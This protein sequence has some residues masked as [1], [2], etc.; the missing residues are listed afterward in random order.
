MNK[1]NK[2]SSKKSALIVL[3]IGPLLFL[4]VYLLV[5]VSWKVKDAYNQASMVQIREQLLLAVSQI[6]KLAPVDNT[7]GD[8]Y[9][10]E[11]KLYLPN[12]GLSLQLT[13]RYE[14]KIDGVSPELTVSTTPVV[15]TNKLYQA[16]NVNEL[17]ENVP[18]VQSCTRG[19]KL[20]YEKL[21]SSEGYANLQHTVRLQNGKDIYV[22]LEKDC[23]ELQ[24]VADLFKD[25]KSY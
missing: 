12:P 5:I 7:N 4:L 25:I 3:L 17:F 8:I 24:D 2:K 13:Y 22:Y 23:P 18:E 15:N 19:V 11:A 14:D 20:K 1:I 9:F 21:P 6:N 16:K 10:P